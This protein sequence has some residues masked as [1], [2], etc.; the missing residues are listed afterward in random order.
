MSG[1]DTSGDSQ[2][3]RPEVQHLAFAHRPLRRRADQIGVGRALIAVRSVSIAHTRSIA[4]LTT[5]VGQTISAMRRLTTDSREKR[6][7]RLPKYPIGRAGRTSTCISR[8]G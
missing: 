5:V 2:L 3:A 7:S 8:F 6:R 1:A 4:A